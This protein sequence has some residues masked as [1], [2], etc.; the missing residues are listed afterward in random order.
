MKNSQKQKVI[1]DSSFEI[2]LQ[3]AYDDGGT[4]NYIQGNVENGFT[5]LGTKR[6]DCA[7][8]CDELTEKI[9]SPQD[10]IGVFKHRSDGTIVLTDL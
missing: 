3:R 5:L 1:T 6:F 9:K 4:E 10:L 7:D 2:L 8:L